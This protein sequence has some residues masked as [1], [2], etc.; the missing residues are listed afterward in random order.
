[1]AVVHRA[2]DAMY[3]E[4]AS[5]LE[6]DAIRMMAYAVARLSL[7]VVSTSPCQLAGS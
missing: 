5:T 7:L 4:M 6:S 2:A 3:A 1:M